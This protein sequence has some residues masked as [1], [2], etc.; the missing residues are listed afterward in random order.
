LTHYLSGTGLA[1]LAAAA[2]PAALAASVSGTPIST[3]QAITPTAAPGA[4]FGTLNPHLKSA[5][6]YVVGQAESIAV[7]PDKKTMLVLT[8]GYNDDP[9][10]ATK[11]EFVFVFDISSGKPVQLQ[12]L[13]VPNAFCG[14]TW[15]PDGSTFYVAGGQD[16]N[17]HTFK[18][19]G[20]TWAE[21]GTPIAL[22]HSAFG[23]TSIPA[24]L[25]LFALPGFGAAVGPL[26]AGLATT[27]DGNRRIS[28]LGR[29]PERRHRLH[30]QSARSRDRHRQP[31]R[32]EA[33]GCGPHQGE[34]QSEPAGP[35]QGGRQSLCD[36]RQFG[37]ALCHQH[38]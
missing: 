2:A 18:K 28:L 35:D 14:V 38:L 10:P 23:Q 32:Q 4:V 21:A 17:V 8:T 16:D 6:K 31:A 34:R 36:R 13:P 12:A 25:G 30:R 20:G 15:G 1:F 9:E 27:A 7:S 26:A 5:P 11:S 19:S 22:K 37:Q 24:G 3:G 29:G 33:A